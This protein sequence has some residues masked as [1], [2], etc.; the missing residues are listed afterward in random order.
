MSFLGCFRS[1]THLCCPC[2]MPASNLLG[3][4]VRRSVGKIPHPTLV[5][6]KLW[7]CFIYLFGRSTYKLRLLGWKPN[8]LLIITSNEITRRTKVPLKVKASGWTVAYKR[9]IPMRCSSP[10]CPIK[11]YV[12]ICGYV[13]EELW[14]QRFLCIFSSFLF[15]SCLL[16][17]W[18]VG[19]IPWDFL[20]WRWSLLVVFIGDLGAT[21]KVLW[22]G[23]L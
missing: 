1:W 12:Q 6:Y 11:L 15:F 21:E 20:L 7:Y 5:N 23:V 8:K 19:L 13:L 4:Y 9:G 10:R 18:L 17:W 14:D 3:L 2:D 22:F 16:W